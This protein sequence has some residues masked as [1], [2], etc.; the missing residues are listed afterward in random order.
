MKLIGKVLSRTMGVSPV[1]GAPSETEI[2]QLNPN[3]KSLLLSNTSWL[4]IAPGTLN[5][6]VSAMDYSL[7]EDSSVSFKESGNE[8][9]YPNGWTHIPKE[10]SEYRYY[11][12]KISTEVVLIR[13]AKNPHNKRVIEIIAEY[14]LR[15]KLDLSDGDK[16]TVELR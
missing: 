12:A 6:E 8:V 5:L 9:I 1:K 14:N 2:L 15:N 11:K 13:C 10:R 3:R 16:V 7:L 4:E